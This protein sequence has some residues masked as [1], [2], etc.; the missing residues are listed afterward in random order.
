MKTI[1]L[2]RRV[3]EQA[4]A[5]FPCTLSL[6]AREIQLQGKIDAS[7]GGVAYAFSALTLRDLHP[8]DVEIAGEVAGTKPTYQLRGG[9]VSVTGYREHQTATEISAHKMTYVD[10]AVVEGILEDGRQV[11]ML[12]VP[13]TMSIAVSS[14]SLVYR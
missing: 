6:K 1:T 10:P 9:R 2:E 7:F 11:R 8:M 12:Q 4:A 14:G 3:E 5:F 13:G